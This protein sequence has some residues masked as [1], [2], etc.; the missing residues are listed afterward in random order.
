M[1][2]R[3]G[4]RNRAKTHAIY[5]ATDDEMQA[6][7]NVWKFDAARDLAAV[8][9]PDD[10]LRVRGGTLGGDEVKRSA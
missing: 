6:N 9:R 8:D 2:E 3:G 7:E 5:Y 1:P 4:K 10:E